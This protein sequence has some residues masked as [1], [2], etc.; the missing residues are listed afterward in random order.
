MTIIPLARSTAGVLP[1]IVGAWVGAVTKCGM[2]LGEGRDASLEMRARDPRDARFLRRAAGP[3]AHG[4][5]RR[6]AKGRRV[7]AGALDSGGYR[8]ERELGT[9]GRT[10]GIDNG[11][12]GSPPYYI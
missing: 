7:I 3:Y 12:P 9:G 10:R 4:R 5:K 11:E 6:R 2:N 1:G 8:G